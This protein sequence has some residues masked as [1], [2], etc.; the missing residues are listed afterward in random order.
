MHREAAWLMPGRAG[1]LHPDGRPAVPLFTDF[2]A[3][4]QTRLLS[5]VALFGEAFPQKGKH[6][7]PWPSMGKAERKPERT[8][9]GKCAGAAS[10]Q[11]DESKGSALC[12]LLESDWTVK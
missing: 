1:P 5:S 4:L 9:R 11:T 7:H 3:C 2:R 6:S 8:L 12:R 10:K